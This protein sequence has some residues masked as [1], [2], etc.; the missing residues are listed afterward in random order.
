MTTA[1]LSVVMPTY[2]HAQFL[3]RALTALLTQSVRPAEVIVVN[4]NSPDETPAILDE[5]ARND[6]AIE[7]I[8]NERNRG[9]NESVEIGI[10]RASAK[11]LFICASDDYVLP[12]FVEKSMGIL[13]QHPEAGLC[14]SYFSIV[15]GVTGVIRPGATGWCDAP[16]YFSPAEIERLVGHTSIPGHASIVKRS[17]FEAAGGFLPDLQWHS[18]WFLN[19]VVAFREGICHVPEMLSLLTDMPASYYNQGARSER[20]R[21][22]LNAV[23]DR[24]AS[25]AYADVAPFFQRSGVLNVLGLP[26]LRA[27]AARPDAWSKNTLGLL[28][29]FREDQYEELLGDDDPSVRDLAAFFLGAFWHETKARRARDVHDRRMLESDLAAKVSDLVAKD[30]Q[31]QERDRRIGVLN[32]EI[33]GRDQKL[34]QAQQDLAEWKQAL[35]NTHLLL[36]E[37]DAQLRHLESMVEDLSRQMQ[38]MESSY[39]WKLRSVLADCKRGLL[40]TLGRGKVMHAGNV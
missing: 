18:D 10:A 32:S 35:A 22:V 36:A 37:R 7:V 20:Q 39:F 4:D 21:A 23:F 24:L 29:G 5:F 19:F 38:R 34:S 12:G 8:H 9:T 1:D 15:D 40:R 17:S 25:P 2:N 6:A 3:P 31:C 27:A 16:R 33:L 14:S 30:Q 13:Q 28:N 11:Y 26:V